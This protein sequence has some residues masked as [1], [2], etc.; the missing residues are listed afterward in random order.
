MS[1][2]SSNKNKRIAKNMLLLFPNA[3]YDG[4]VAVCES[5]HIKCAWS[6]IFRS[7]RWNCDDF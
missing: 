1:N 5:R 2:Q 7:D 4:Y 3:L 6:G